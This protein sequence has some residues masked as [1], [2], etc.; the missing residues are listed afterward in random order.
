MR[1]EEP[2]VVDIGRKEGVVL[3]GEPSYHALHAEYLPKLQ[4][5]D[6]R[7]AV[8]NLAIGIPLDVEHQE[9]V[10]EE[11]HVVHQRKSSL[12]EDIRQVG[13]R[14]DKQ[15]EGHLVPLCAALDSHV[16]LSPTVEPDSF[17]DAQFGIVVLPWKR[18]SN[19]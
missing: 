16:A 11:L 10:V 14:E 6:K 19:Y 7:Y 4:F 17:I 15:R 9:A 5:P 13:W 3:V 12:V 18:Q 2:L 1:C 8:E